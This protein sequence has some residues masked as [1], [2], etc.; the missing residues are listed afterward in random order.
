MQLKIGIHIFFQLAIF[1][2][3]NK[4]TDDGSTLPQIIAQFQGKWRNAN[5]GRISISWQLITPDASDCLDNQ[6]ELCRLYGTRQWEKRKGKERKKIVMYL[7]KK[8]APKVRMTSW[9]LAVSVMVSCCMS[10]ST[11]AINCA[12][13]LLGDTGLVSNNA[14]SPLKYL[15][16]ITLSSGLNWQFLA[17]FTRSFFPMNPKQ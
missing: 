16:L 2:A 11:L 14:L 7:Q 15:A 6:I 10:L 1:S 3:K 5:G 8:N 13:A 4:S 12:F 9:D 17:C